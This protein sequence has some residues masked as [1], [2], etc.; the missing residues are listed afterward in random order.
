MRD[1]TRNINEAFCNK[2]QHLV[3]WHNIGHVDGVLIVGRK[4][5]IMELK[6]AILSTR[7]ILDLPSSNLLP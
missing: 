6:Q 7:P 5:F 1:S 4:K 3:C 2:A